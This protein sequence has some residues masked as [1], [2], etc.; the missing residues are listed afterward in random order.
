MPVKSERSAPTKIPLLLGSVF[1]VS[2]S[3][4]IL[5]V[6]LTRIFSVRLW[7]HYV[8]LVVSS[9]LLGFGLGG[10]VVAKLRDRAWGHK[11][12]PKILAT[13][14]LFFSISALLVTIY[15][16]QR[17]PTSFLLIYIVPSAVPFFFAGTFLAFVFDVFTPQ[18]AKIY[19]ADLIGAATGS[20]GVLFLLDSF[21]AIN[22]ALL[23][24][25]FAS[26]AGLVVVFGGHM[27]RWV[28]ACA[29]LCLISLVIV[30]V[31]LRSRVIDISFGKGS[32]G[33]GKTIVKVLHQP[34]LKARIVATDW[35]L[36]ARTDVVEVEGAPFKGI[37]TDGGALTKMVAFD[38]EDYGSLSY[39]K[40]EVGF[41]PF[42]WGNKEKTL[43]I[44]AG[45]GKDLLLAL[46]GGSKE[47]VGVEISPGIVRMAEAFSKYNGDLF[48]HEKVKVFVADGRNFVRRSKEQ[49]D[50]I[51]LG[52]VCSQAAELTGFALSENYIY[53]EEAFEDYLSHLKEEGRL[54]LIMHDQ[55]G[56]YK[57]VNTALSVL[58]KKELTLKQA[59]RHIA[60]FD[61]RRPESQ[62][63]SIASP[64]LIVKKIPFREDKIREMIEAAG[65]QKI[66][67]LYVPG[68]YER[69]PYAYMV[70]SGKSLQDIM[71]EMIRLSHINVSPATDDRP[72]FYHFDPGIP[73]PVLTLLWIAMGATAA[74][75][76][77]FLFRRRRKGVESA[78]EGNIKRG[79]L[80]MYFCAL[81]IG[82]MG[83]EI[84]LMQ[85]LILFIGYPTLTFSVVLF[86]LLLSGG[87]GSHAS[88]FVRWE[89]MVKTVS[90]SALG[91]SILTLVYIWSL[92]P[93][94]RIFLGHGTWV[95]SMVA[96]M[97]IMPLGFLMGIPFPNG[98]KMLKALYPND[99]GLMWGI[100][101]VT[102]VL[103][104]VLA[105][106]ISMRFGFSRCL[107]LS[108]VLYF[109]VF[110][111]AV[112]WNRKDEIISRLASPGGPAV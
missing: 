98:L 76:I 24:G 75:V 29:S 57:A 3:V 1:L 54:V 31:N 17:S 95:R 14:A 86:S 88:G 64:L 22:A 77:W 40:K 112:S 45:G 60:M 78:F 81:G 70:R 48:H 104:S 26:L 7:Y 37:F 100:N 90:W 53:T 8:F 25:P 47:V 32:Y 94:F 87:M 39:L 11:N 82:F 85:R 2:M 63:A 72:F 106:V 68:H 43:V 89:R 61:E 108:V 44:G 50:V 97:L 28:L 103:G 51:Y 5:Q 21:G 6:S 38:G 58:M 92:F 74:L 66:R 55:K 4:F 33:V 59:F 23:V 101:G 46:L 19:A 79:Y 65:Y 71:S 15:I 18:A 13:L 20:L 110:V 10:A 107:M 105:L 109:S 80:L 111:L 102:S 56:L 84:V 35:D 41:F 42:R 96:A 36:F 69:E 30:G 83:I 67:F 73:M 99:L 52:Q 34:M 9:A 91:I 12:P 16:V 93:I 49:Y 62:W 27:R